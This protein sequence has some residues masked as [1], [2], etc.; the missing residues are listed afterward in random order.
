MN[1]KRFF[2]YSLL[3]ASSVAA[4]AGCGK[5][6][7]ATNQVWIAFAEC[8]FGREYVEKWGEAYN[9]AN[10]NDKIKL[11]IE[12]DAGMTADMVTRIQ[13]GKNLPDIALLLATNWQ[14]WAAKGQLEC[15]DDV[16]Q[17]DVGDG[18]GKKMIET[19]DEGV[20]EFGKVNGKYYACPW[21]CGP[22]GIIYNVGMFED[23]GWE[24]PTTYDELVDLC[25]QINKDTQG[26]VKPFSYSTSVSGYW[27][28]L[29]STWV[30]QYDGIDTWKEFWKFGDKKVFDS[31][32]REKALECF[33][34]LICDGGKAK[35]CITNN[36]MMDSQ[37]DFINGKAAMTVNG[38]W[39]ENEM[40]ANIEDG[41]EMAMMKTPAIDGAKTT[42]VAFNPPLDFII[43][44]AKAEH[45]DYAK[46]FLAF[47]NSKKGCEIFAKYANGLR[48]FSHYK[49]S[50]ES[51]ASNFMKS[52]AKIQE[53]CTMCYQVSSNPMWYENMVGMW[54]GYGTPYGK[55]IQDDEDADT[56]MSNIHTYVDS[57]WDDWK[58][59]V[60]L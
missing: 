41:F 58:K 45:K 8:G 33:Y 54:P 1:G 4:L 25:D 53:S 14:P 7:S 31:E 3:L 40:K 28:Y 6:S 56:V 48:P 15:L 43:V 38:S 5:T 35:N 55:M 16:Y 57:C 20:K 12:G 42:D 46:K 27:D 21:S 10:P 60:G 17:A 23:F 47:M 30:A 50:E 49:A 32:G 44:P 9:E 36:L 13:S 22:S 39:F 19:I 26:S 2:Q 11:K 24:V 37:R 51:T 34:D 29:V 52:C 18:S 59:Q